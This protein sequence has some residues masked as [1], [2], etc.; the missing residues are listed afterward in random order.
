[1]E[2]N[3]QKQIEDL[4][5]K[6]FLLQE[7]LINAEAIEQTVIDKIKTE[8]D[9]LVLN[10]D[11]LEVI[12]QQTSL[13]DWYEIDGYKVEAEKE[14]NEELYQSQLQLFKKAGL[15]ITQPGC[16]QRQ[17]LTSLESSLKSSIEFEDGPG[18]INLDLSQTN[19]LLPYSTEEIIADSGSSACDLLETEKKMASIVTVVM[20]YENKPNKYIVDDFVKIF[21]TRLKFI[22]NVLHNRRELQNATAIS[23]IQNKTEREE[24][25]LI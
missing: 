4:F 22:E 18:K 24:V 8:A 9:L 23:R 17:V 12:R 7:D 1:M 6:G 11:Y 19:S 14:R 21:R 3:P 2:K 20:S 25:S 10:K 16:Q 13:V 15:S 5:K